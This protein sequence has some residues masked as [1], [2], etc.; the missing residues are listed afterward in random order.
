VTWREESR[1]FA[2]VEIAAHDFKHVLASVR[3]ETTARLFPEGVSPA[4]GMLGSMDFN[5]RMLNDTGEVERLVPVATK[6]LEF[7]RR[8]ADEQMN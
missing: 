2:I 4:T 3:E 7:L 5:D 6:A 1:E 8:K